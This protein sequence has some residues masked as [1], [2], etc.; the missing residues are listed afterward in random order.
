MKRV[1]VVGAGPTGLAVG[2]CLKEVG[3]EP[4]I[5]E[6]SDTVGSSW[7]GHYD[8]L[9]LHTIRGRSGLP[10]LPMPE[11][12]G[13]YPSR[14]AVIAYL[15]AYAAK[16]GLRP[17]FGCE[18]TRIRREGP[19]WR[20]TH[21]QG[22]E[23]AATLVMATGLNGRPS[24]PDWPGDFDGPVLHSSAYRN[25]TPF[26][27]QRVLVVGFGNSGGDIALDLA[28]AGVD[29]TLSVRG[30]V[31]ILPKEL[32]GMPI[33]S[34]GVMSRLLGPRLADRLT[35]PILR[36]KIGR[37]EDYGLQSHEK[38][39]ATMVAE[40]GRIPLIDVGTLGAIRDGSIR[41]APGIARLDGDQLWF[42]DGSNL[43]MEA[44]IA[45]TGYSADLRPLLGDNCAALDDRGHPRVSGAPSAEPGLYFCSYHASSTG[46]LAASAQEARAIAA[47]LAPSL[48]DR[49]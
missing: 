39:P 2:A 30:P 28:R 11:S 1:I 8:S 3:T 20:V 21:S 38:G 14:D 44:I 9:H 42:T 29:V 37:P 18:V 32:F 22:A 27:G 35:A 19:V 41:V 49:G 47:H 48:P 16:H 5:L 43:P 26:A 13:R 36:A 10:G 6:K 40:D 12:A 17:K 46:Q 24:L 23:E 34:F 45:A 7:R 31:Q 25:A 33:T 4:V 15:D